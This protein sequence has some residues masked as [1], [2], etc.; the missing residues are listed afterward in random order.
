MKMIVIGSPG[1]GKTY[2]SQIICQRLDLPCL[3]LDVIWHDMDYSSQA[4]ERFG[5]LL[6][7]FMQGHERWL[8]DGNFQ[9]SLA[10]RLAEADHVVWLKRPRVFNLLRVLKRSLLFA[11]SSSSRPE[12]PKTFKESLDRDYLTFLAFVWQFSKS[13]PAME[14]QL[15]SYDG[16]VSVL[17]SK[18]EMDAFLTSLTSLATD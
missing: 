8:I 7:E 6:F 13:Y 2:L 10:I 5:Q 16:K 12:M 11:F 3:H 4:E 18:K 14:K 9:N 17:R 1:S 15:Q